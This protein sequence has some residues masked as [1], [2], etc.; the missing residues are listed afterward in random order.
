MKRLQIDIQEKRYPGSDTVVLESLSMTVHEGEFVA[1]VGPSGAGKT[2]LMN[3]IAGLDLSVDGRV[4]LSDS[5]AAAQGESRSPKTGYVFQSPRLMPWMT[6]ADNLRLVLGGESDVE[7]RIVEILDAVGLTGSADLFPGELSGG[8]QRRAGIARAFVIEP[9]ILLLDEPFVSVDAPTAQRLRELL[10]TLWARK[11][12]MVILISHVLKEAI[13]LA[14]RIVF[15]SANPGSVIHEM[16]VN[17][18]RPR[19]LQDS[20]VARIHDELLLEH[21]DLLSG[22][23]GNPSSENVAAV[24]R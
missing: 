21:P 17:C 23:T 2:T 13:A 5:E 3:I 12:P 4:V 11:R 7:H 10:M 15:M 8:M 24:E 1:V 18:D 14:D 22:L 9:D 19:T 20:A 16:D 6:I